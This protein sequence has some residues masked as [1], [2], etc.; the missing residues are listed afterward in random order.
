MRIALALGGALLVACGER[1]RRELSWDWKPK[2]A[3]I[4]NADL[5]ADGSITIA[6]IR[7]FGSARIV[8]R[9]R[10]DV[11]SVDRRGAARAR[12]KYVQQKV[13]A[14]FG[15][16]LEEWEFKNGEFVRPPA[17]ALEA[18]AIKES[19][20]KAGRISISRI[21]AIDYLDDSP[22]CKDLK[23]SGNILGPGVPGESIEPG[24]TWDI[25]YTEDFDEPM[26][27]RYAL[28]SYHPH[29]G[30]ECAVFTA[31][32]SDKGK[33]KG[34]L[35]DFHYKA[36]AHFDSDRGRM[37]RFRIDVIVK[38]SMKQQLMSGST[39]LQVTITPP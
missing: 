24:E 14:R 28:E 39:V 10:I 2:T 15:D 23:E 6:G 11:E 34:E 37:I 9:Y 4:V 33:N 29:D 5:D 18:A 12:I 32:H 36:L 25:V 21:G 13:R 3:L 22:I 27:I 20:N 8:T 35:V 26:P 31:D 30:S 1:G 17:N 16:D 38:S 19:L 7:K